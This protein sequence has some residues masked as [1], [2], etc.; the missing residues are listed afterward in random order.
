MSRLVSSL[1]SL[2]LEKCF[3]LFLH[4]VI[5]NHSQ[6]ESVCKRY[7]TRTYMLLLREMDL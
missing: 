6:V 4:A 5:N 3:F 7:L 1:F 2:P